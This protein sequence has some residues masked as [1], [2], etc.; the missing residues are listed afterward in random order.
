MGFE[1]M[2][3]SKSRNLENNFFW[4]NLYKRITYPT[5]YQGN[6]VCGRVCD[7]DP[8][9]RAGCRYPNITRLSSQ[10]QQEKFKSHQ[11]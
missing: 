4:D 1:P 6:T 7:G 2:I 5:T 8:L 11:T 3:I 9:Y 10:P